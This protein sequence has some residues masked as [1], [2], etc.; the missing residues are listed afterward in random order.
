MDLSKIIKNCKYQVGKHS[1]EILT[2][3]GI[4]GMIT[5]TIMAVKAT[6]KAMDI[7]VE[8][9][10]TTDESNKKEMGKQIITKVLPVYIPSAVLG[11]FSVACII[12]ALSVNNKRN[13]ALLTAYTLSEDALK[14]YQTKVVE[15]IGKKKEQNIR[16]EIA[17]D[18][19]NKNPV[20]SSE[21]IITSGETLCYDSISGRYFMSDVEKLRRVENELNRRLIEEMYVSL[22]DLYYEI[23]LKRT[24]QGDE[25]GFNIDD[26]LIDFEFSAQIADDNRPC[27][28]LGYHIGPRYG[29]SELGYR[30]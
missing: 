4:A 14:E 26:G 7:M 19:I 23:G 20:S 6:P 28:V 29:Y 30:R 15:T 2:G 21:V 8:I 3:V 17:K 27:I 16:D 11:G 13:A 25:L 1:P 9:K 24:E 10:E 18:T 12:G 22:N 5:T